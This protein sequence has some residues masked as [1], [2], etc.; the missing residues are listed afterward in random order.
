P[1]LMCCLLMMRFITFF[2]ILT[3]NHL[4]DSPPV[5]LGCYAY[6]DCSNLCSIC[7]WP[8]C[9]T[10]CEVVPAHRD[11][12]CATF[13][14]AKVRFT[15]VENCSESCLQYECI[16]PLRVLLAMEKNKARWDEEVNRMETHTDKRKTKE[17]WNFYQVNV[18]DFLRGPCKL[19]GKFDE[20]LIHQVCGILDINTF[21]ARTQCGNMI[22]CLYP[23]LAMMSHN[24]VSN[25]THSIYTDGWGTPEDYRVTARAT[26]PLKKGEELFA[27]YTYSLWPTMIRREYLREGKYF[28]CNCPRCSDPTEL[29]THMSTLKCTKNLCDNGVIYSTNPL[30]DEAEWK[31]THC[32]NIL[33]GATIRKVFKTIQTEMD[34]VDA[35]EQ[36]SS[37]I[38]ARE[39]LYRK[40]RSVLHPRNAFFTI[41]RI[42][43]AQ[44][45]GKMEGYTMDLLPDV[46]FER[47]VELCQQILENINVIEPGW[48]R[49]RGIIMYELHA[50]LIMLARNLYN[51]NAIDK[52]Q[53]RA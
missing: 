3:S 22:R 7:G 34:Q 27:S 6:I 14:G 40:Y 18:V 24:C 31:C 37:T 16:T 17:I 21:E 28:E 19:G 30:D 44:M 36:D 5:C 4:I 23:T 9:D 35:M 32:Q 41:L 49:L 33:Q 25:V 50:P 38:E 46:L 13:A 47:K 26:V 10:D 51:T 45:Y 43:L 42:S 39:S 53:L 8:V 52:E 29:G 20:D 11:A 48:S 12:E 15:P 2:L 1:I